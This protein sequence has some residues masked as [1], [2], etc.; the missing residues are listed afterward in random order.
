MVR[1]LKRRRE[2]KAVVEDTWAR[3]KREH[4]KVVGVAI[5]QIES[6]AS[7]LILK[8]KLAHYLKACQVFGKLVSG[9]MAELGDA[10]G[11]GPYDF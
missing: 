10:Y 7:F 9:R 11:S 5:S 3:R 2:S 1:A 6:K 8:S 4:I